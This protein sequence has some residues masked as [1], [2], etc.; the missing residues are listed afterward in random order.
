MRTNAALIVLLL[1]LLTIFAGGAFAEDP[2][3]W[4]APMSAYPNP[5]APSQPPPAYYNQ[6]GNQYPYAGTWPGYGHAGYQPYGSPNQSWTQQN[7]QTPPNPPNPQSPQPN[8]S[9]NPFVYR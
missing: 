3:R 4:S 6:Y 1:I 8:Y 5:W 2:I 9:G 7:T